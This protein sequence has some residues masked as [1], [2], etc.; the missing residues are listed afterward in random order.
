MKEPKKIVK[1]KKIKTPNEKT[2][3]GFDVIEFKGIKGK[4]YKL[5]YE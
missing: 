3:V 5:K 1:R 2:Y 4:V